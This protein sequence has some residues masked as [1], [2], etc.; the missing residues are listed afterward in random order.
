[1]Y[2]VIIALLLIFS[3]S[4]SKA[5]GILDWQTYG[6]NT[7]PLTKE[8]KIGITLFNVAQ[9]IDMLQTFEIVG[10]DRY[11]ETNPILGKYPSYA[12]VLGY[13]VIRGVAHWKITELIPQKYRKA[14]LAVSIIP[15]IDTIHNNHKIGIRISW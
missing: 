6:V 3:C 2:K 9:G 13:F 14:W 8:D 12:E 11:Y 10:D 5:E 7:E 15:Q 1:M 4:V